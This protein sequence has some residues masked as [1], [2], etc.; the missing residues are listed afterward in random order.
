MNRNR[1][2]QEDAP[3]PCRRYALRGFSGIANV[4][5]REHLVDTE[6][7]YSP[8]EKSHDGRK[9]RYGGGAFSQLNGWRQ[10]RPIARGDH[11]AGGEAHHGI[12]D[13]PGYRLEEEHE[14]S[15]ECGYTPG[16]QS[17]QQG[18]KNWVELAKPCNKHPGSL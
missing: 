17:G 11:N 2:H 5:V 1:E 4:E 3:T 7:R 13:L 12:Q 15:A 10:E 18:L 9:P 8:R 6:H 16:E 14:R